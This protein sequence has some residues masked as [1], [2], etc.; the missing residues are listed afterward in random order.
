[1]NLVRLLRVLLCRRGYSP[2]A[3]LASA[4][5]QTMGRETGDEFVAFLSRCTMID[6]AVR[7]VRKVRVSRGFSRKKKQKQIVNVQLL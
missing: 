4:P 1:M 5:L 6:A 3:G 7:Y 2:V